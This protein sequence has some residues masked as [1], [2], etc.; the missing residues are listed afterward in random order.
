MFILEINFGEND[1]KQLN[2]MERRAKIKGAS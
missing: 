2:N 1:L